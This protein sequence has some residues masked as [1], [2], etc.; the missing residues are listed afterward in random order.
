MSHSGTLDKHGASHTERRVVV[1][2]PL[3]VCCPRWSAGRKRCRS[4]SG[5]GVLLRRQRSRATSWSLARPAAE[6]ERQSEGIFSTN[7]DDK[8]VGYHPKSDR[9]NTAYFLFTQDNNKRKE[10]FLTPLPW[11]SPAAFGP[12][13]GW[14]CSPGAS[15]WRAGG[16]GRALGRSTAA[17]PGHPHAPGSLGSAWG[18]AP[19]SQWGKSGSQWRFQLPEFHLGVILNVS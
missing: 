14:G 3:I 1:W 18:Q 19:L 11:R 9:I 8:L 17:S 15:G 16:G 2:S 13:S 4:P 6:E 10:S 12:A 5:C 7:L